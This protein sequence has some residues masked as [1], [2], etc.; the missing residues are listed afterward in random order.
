MFIASITIILRLNPF[1]IAIKPRFSPGRRHPLVGLRSY[2]GLKRS[3][4]L[5]KRYVE[6]ITRISHWPGF[7]SQG[8]YVLSQFS[9]SRLKFCNALHVKAARAYTLEAMF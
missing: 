6:Y 8:T 2:S 5:R 4:K 3:L 1:D 9:V 7:N